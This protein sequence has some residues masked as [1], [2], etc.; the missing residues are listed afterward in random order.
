M[1]LTKCTTPFAARHD[2]EKQYQ[3]L[4]ATIEA[5]LNRMHDLHWEKEDRYEGYIYALRETLPDTADK[6][7][8]VTEIYNALGYSNTDE[9][10]TSIQSSLAGLAMNAN[11]AR[12]NF[13]FASKNGEEYRVED[14]CRLAGLTADYRETTHHYAELDD[15]GKVIHKWDEDT[16]EPVYWFD[17]DWRH[18]VYD[19]N[20]E[21]NNDDD[22]KDWG[23]E[24]DDDEDED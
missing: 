11:K 4:R 20:D 3:E 1:S 7:L 13:D 23:E 17:A 6:A 16:T 10:I 15:N 5:T 14:H 8:S 24:D 19:D 21:Y 9:N 22:D 12:I 18:Y 2:L